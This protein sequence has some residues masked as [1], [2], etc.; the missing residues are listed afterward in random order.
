[1]Q[2]IIFVIS[3]PGPSPELFYDVGKMGPIYCFTTLPV[4]TWVTKVK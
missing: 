2:K 3:H 1:M 4:E